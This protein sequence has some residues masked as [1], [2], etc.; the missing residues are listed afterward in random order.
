M[1]RPVARAAL[2]ALTLGF[3]RLAVAGA[4]DAESRTIER[5]FAAES[6]K[7]FRVKGNVGKIVVVTTMSDS[8][9]LRLDLRVRTQHGLFGS[10][11]GDPHAVELDA[12]SGADTIAFGLRYAG[13][14][15]GLDETWTLEVPARLAAR[16]E[17]AV[18]DLDVRG[19]EGGVKLSVNVGDIEAEV[20]RGDITARTNVGDIRVT[21]ATDS[22]GDVELEASVGDTH[23]TQGAHRVRH[24]KPAG[25]GNRIS[26]DGP[27]RDR[28]QLKT[29]VGDATLV[30]ST[31]T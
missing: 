13:D 18:G 8:I 26:L 14:R 30:L 20:P 22:Y 16:L 6:L 17:L 23:L 12:D 5:T 29:S 10:R 21:S 2:F 15:D 31:S 1:K 24:P 7:D 28:I 3:A 25:A 27:G 4:D 9:R 11:K 19:L